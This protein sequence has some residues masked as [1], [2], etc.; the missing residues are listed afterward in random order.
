MP[1]IILYLL[2]GLMLISCNYEM[3]EG[4]LSDGRII[5]VKQYKD[6][7]VEEKHYLNS[8]FDYSRD[9]YSNNLI[10]SQIKIDT[11][12]SG[13]I[14]KLDSSKIYID[15]S[16]EEYLSLFIDGRI[17]SNMVYPELEK[18]VFATTN[19]EK[20]S[21]TIEYIKELENVK[22]KQNQ[23]KFQMGTY[24]VKCPCFGPSSEIFYFEITFNKLDS[25]IKGDKLNFIKEGK[26]TAFKSK[27]HI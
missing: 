16:L 20:N 6:P 2:I 1:S 11:N 24:I 18:D 19:W 3:V 23:R 27:K 22:N 9:N 14:V 21:C 5:K 17:N 25:K 26:I 10:Q 8:F 7:K 13:Y 4:E 12:K 15:K